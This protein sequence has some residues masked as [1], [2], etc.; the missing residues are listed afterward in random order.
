M[1]QAAD[2]GTDEKHPP[3]ATAR[4]RL[5][6][7]GVALLA[8]AFVMG[9]VVFPL[10]QDLGLPQAGYGR[11][12]YTPVCHQMPERSL[13]VDGHPL[14]VCARCS[15]LYLGGLLGLYLGLAFL[16]RR[17]LRPRPVWLAIA[18]LP[19]LIDV[20]VPR[21]GLV[22]LANLP[23]LWLAVP[24][25]VLLGIFLAIGIHDLFLLRVLTR[26][27]RSDGSVSVLEGL[28]G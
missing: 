2:T 3:R 25:G 24:L 5:A 16:I 15:G 7:L 18:A 17:N 8:T 27:N 19:T 26:S 11:L 13:S 4:A 14:G 23:R 20:L 6:L 1:R 9:I 21:I 12:L 10:L 28:D 22:G